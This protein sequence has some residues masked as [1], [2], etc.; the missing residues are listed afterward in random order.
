MTKQQQAKDNQ[1]G[2]YSRGREY[3]WEDLLD[4][5]FRGHNIKRKKLYI[6]DVG[7][8]DGYL[9]HFIREY[10]FKYGSKHEVEYVGLDIWPGYKK[11]IENNGGRFVN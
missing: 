5:I 9:S 10:N 8:G 7:C 11:M 4:F 1:G 3:R 6:L 2:N